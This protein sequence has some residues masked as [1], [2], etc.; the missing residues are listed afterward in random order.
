M[1]N[2]NKTQKLKIKP[3][4]LSYVV[5]V[6]PS[7][8]PFVCLY[9]ISKRERERS[10]ECKNEILMATRKTDTNSK[11]EWDACDIKGDWCGGKTGNRKQRQ[12]RAGAEWGNGLVRTKYTQVSIWK[13]CSK[14]WLCKTTLKFKE[15]S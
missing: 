1:Q 4:L 2:K 11:R 7:I 13:W 12:Q 3:L 6:H 9:I 8:R 5:S 10:P 15:E 14:P